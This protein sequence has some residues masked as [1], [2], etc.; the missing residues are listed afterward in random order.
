MAIKRKHEK[1]PP[2]AYDVHDP[3]LDVIYHVFSYERIK[4]DEVYPRY[5]SQFLGKRKRTM[6]VNWQNLPH[7]VKLI[8]TPDGKVAPLDLST[9]RQFDQEKKFHNQRKKRMEKYLEKKKKS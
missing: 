2:F 9:Q 8:V 3:R 5:V 6:P 4:T 7:E 1:A